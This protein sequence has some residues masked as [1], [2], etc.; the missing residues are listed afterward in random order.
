MA[1]RT[2]QAASVV[3]S[4]VVRRLPARRPAGQGCLGLNGIV[5]QL[6]QAAA[7]AAAAADDLMMRAAAAVAQAFRRMVWATF[8]VERGA[9]RRLIRTDKFQEVSA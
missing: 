8:R 5:V 3:G 4:F 7:A 6:G 2:G 9:Q 1:P